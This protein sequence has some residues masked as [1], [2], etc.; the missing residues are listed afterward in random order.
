MY[1]FGAEDKAF[2][3]G[4]EFFAQGK[5]PDPLRN[6]KFV[7]VRLGIGKH[8]FDLFDFRIL[9]ADGK[10]FM[11]GEHLFDGHIHTFMVAFFLIVVKRLRAFARENA[12]AGTVVA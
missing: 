7:G 9:L 11:R 2:D 4:M 6:E 5:Q 1:V 12:L 8:A 10:K 3:G